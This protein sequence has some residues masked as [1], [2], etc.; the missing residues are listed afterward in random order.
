M[1]LRI[2]IG[3]DADGLR[4]AAHSL[5]GLSGLF[6]QDRIARLA[7]GME[8]LLDR[9]RLGKLALDDTTLDALVEGLDVLQA[10]LVDASRGETEFKY[11]NHSCSPNSYMRTCYG[12]VEFYSLRDFRRGEEITCDYGITHHDGKKPCECGSREG[13]RRPRK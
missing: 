7:H 8:D 3:R 4:R 2:E 1:P 10:L 9:L 11:I 13:R 12:K 6:G 5:K